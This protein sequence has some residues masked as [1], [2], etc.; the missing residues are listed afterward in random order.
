MFTAMSLTQ[1]RATHML[2]MLRIGLISINSY[3]NARSIT[4]VLHATVHHS[5]DS[6]SSWTNFRAYDISHISSKNITMIAT[7]WIE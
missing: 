1:H 6:D 3:V 5:C 4:A 7:Q 2:P